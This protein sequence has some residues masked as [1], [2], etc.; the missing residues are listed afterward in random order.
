MLRWSAVRRATCGSCVSER[1]C[2]DRLGVRIVGALSGRGWGSRTVSMLTRRGLPSALLSCVVT[3]LS[4]ACFFALRGARAVRC[5]GRGGAWRLL[6]WAAR[7]GVCWSAVARRDSWAHG[8][9]SPHALLSLA[10]LAGGGGLRRVC[11]VLSCGRGQRGVGAALASQRAR[12]VVC[13]ALGFGRG[14]PAG[15]G[16]VKNS[17]KQGAGL[18]LRAPGC[19]ARGGCALVDMRRVVGVSCRRGSC[20]LG[21]RPGRGCLASC[22]HLGTTGGHRNVMLGLAAG[23]YC[24]GGF[25]SV[26]GRTGRARDKNYCKKNAIRASDGSIRVC[27]G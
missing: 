21:G 2:V 16:R 9:R 10:A 12:G 15:S 3:A 17:E 25:V 4:G 11:S 5:S 20:R 1:S 26:V 22:H 13:V 6:A 8:C 14:L 18:S 23:D 19:S 27:P 7:L 24:P